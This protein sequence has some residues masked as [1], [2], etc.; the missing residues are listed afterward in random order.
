ETGNI[1]TVFVR[2]VFIVFLYIAFYSCVYFYLNA[3]ISAL[4]LL[5]GCLVFTPAILLMERRNPNVARACFHISC[6]FYVYAT[7]FGI[8]F[9]LD[10]DFYYMATLLIPV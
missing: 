2:M 6:L 5:L 1:R 9:P 10:I 8:R 4:M 3:R 7:P